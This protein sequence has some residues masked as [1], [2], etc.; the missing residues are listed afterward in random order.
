MELWLPYLV[1]DRMRE[2]RAEAAHVR[3]RAGN[4]SVC[5]GGEGTARDCH[6]P[7]AARVEAVARRGRTMTS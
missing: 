5:A 4:D 7:H 1:E 2:R 6:P 3:A